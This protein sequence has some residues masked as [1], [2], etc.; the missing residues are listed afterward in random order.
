MEVCSVCGSPFPYAR[1]CDQA[2]TGVCHDCATRNFPAAYLANAEH[3]AHRDS[4]PRP[5]PVPDAMPERHY[6]WLE[7]DARG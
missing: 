7:E 3:P 2:H 4:V 1:A 5:R 6:P